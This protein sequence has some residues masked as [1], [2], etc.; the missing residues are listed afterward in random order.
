MAT[1]ADNPVTEPVLSD[2]LYNDHTPAKETDGPTDADTT[3][4]DTVEDAESAKD[5]AESASDTDETVDDSEAEPDEELF[6]VQDGDKTLKVNRKELV[7]GYTRLSDYTRKTKI[8]AEERKAVEA[9]RAKVDDTVKVLS[10]IHEEV[11]SL[12][13]GDLKQVDWDAVRTTDPSEYLRLKEVKAEREKTLDEMVKKRNQIIKAKTDAESIELHKAL[14]WNDDAKKKQADID[15]IT[16]FVQ[17]RGITDQV[18][19][20]K[21]MLAILDA[22]NYHKLQKAQA[23]TLVELKKAPKTTKP[24]KTTKPPQPKSLEDLL[25]K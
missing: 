2:L 3:D 17:E 4:K 14:G 19:S 9:E 21:L 20:H 16:G 13:M 1:V 22:A 18:T 5:E 25:Y 7:D 23:E 12:I 10:D 15:L 6:D 8:V 11:Q 24:V